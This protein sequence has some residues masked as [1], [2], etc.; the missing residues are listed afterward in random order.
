MQKFAVINATGAGAHAV[1]PAVPNQ[2][3]RV[4]AFTALSTSNV[5]LQF[6]SDSTPITGPMPVLAS[7]GMATSI[8]QLGTGGHGV[9]GLMETEAG[10]ALNLNLS[11]AAI[12]GG[13]LTYYLIGQP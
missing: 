11:G 2:K 4:L 5:T 9:F 3:I 10:E 12:V 1:V 6:L 13:F 7:G 8:G